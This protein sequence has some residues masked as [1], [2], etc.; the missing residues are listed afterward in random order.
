MSD[1]QQGAA[2]V[3]YKGL[4]GVPVDVTAISKVNPETNS[5]LYRGYPVQELAASKSFEEVAW[6]LWH[7]DLPTEEELAGLIVRERGARTLEPEIRA[8]VDA[9]PTTAHPMDVVR[10]AVSVMGALDP[11]T[12]DASP[13]ANLAK[14]ERLWAKLPA[15]IA[16]DQRRRR[17]LEPIEPDPELDYSANFL[18]MAF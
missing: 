9:L 14:A 12:D 1:Q 18:W 17:G 6:L 4:A 11:T 3:I 13:E 7:G 2:P 5:L 16:W 8:I 15:V 10:T